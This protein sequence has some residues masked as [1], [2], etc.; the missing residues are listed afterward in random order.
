MKSIKRIPVLMIILSIL[1]LIC[2]C[3]SSSDSAEPQSPKVPVNVQSVCRAMTKNFV[4]DIL[5]EDYSMLAFNVESFE[6]DENA[7]GSVKILY[8]PTAESGATKVN[9]TIVKSGTTYKIE[10]ALLA[11]L[12]EVDL[13]QIPE[14]QITFIEQ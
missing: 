5:A 11:G 1:T 3:G 12:Y 14:K 9:L 4:E 10:Y 6:L 13:S 7:D 8:F 2:G